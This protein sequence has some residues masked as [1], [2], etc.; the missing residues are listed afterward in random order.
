MTCYFWR[1]ST[2]TKSL[3]TLIA[4]VQALLLDD[5]TRF[6]TATVTA[7]V[8]AALKEINQRAPI[9]AATLIDV[10]A[11]QKDYEL[12]DSVDAV[13][14][15]AISDILAWDADG[16]DHESLTYDAYNEDERLFFRLREAQAA[17]GFILA[18]FTIPYTVNGL[19]SATES[20]IPMFYN[21]ILIDGACFYACQIRSVG[22]V[23]TINLNQ[24]VSQ[25]LR[26]ARIYYR[27]AFDIGL[28]L[29]ARKKPA[30]SQPD[31]RAWN[32]SYAGWNQ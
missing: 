3:T 16:D 10:V 27:Q 17:G 28:A 22:R 29:M 2:M 14:A 9:N 19:D 32:D 18:R 24:G 6:S 26:D 5:G 25:S 23:E 4:N 11:S 13:N 20:T 31:L 15:I 1:K 21:D 8:R 7:A 12:T 30:S